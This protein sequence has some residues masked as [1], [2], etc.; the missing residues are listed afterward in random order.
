MASH[1]NVRAAGGEDI[2]VRLGYVRTM[3]AQTI[4]AVGIFLT[5]LVGCDGSGDARPAVDSTVAMDMDMDITQGPGGA[6]NGDV[7]G[8]SRDGGSGA[9]G[10]GAGDLNSGTGG[11]GAGSGGGGS[12]FAS[13]DGPCVGGWRDASTELC[14]QEPG[15]LRKHNHEEATAYCAALTIDG[16]AGWRVPSI[17]ES[18]TI[19]IRCPANTGHEGTCAVHDDSASVDVGPDCSGCDGIACTWPSQLSGTC[20]WLYWSSSEVADW[21]GQ[22]VWIVNFSFGSIGW[23]S[24]IENFLVRCVRDAPG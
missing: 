11:T 8:D 21:P 6:A 20:G 3:S 13:D 7:S 1:R 22:G 16:K 12:P 9:G 2:G 24:P 19:I 4:A 14:W 10:S 17:D 23:D 5:L 18:R 15:D